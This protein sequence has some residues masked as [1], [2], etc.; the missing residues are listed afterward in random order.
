MHRNYISKQK[1]ANTIAL[2][3]LR[4]PSSN[5][6]EASCGLTASNGIEDSR[7]PISSS[8]VHHKG[9]GF[10]GTIKRPI[11]PLKLNV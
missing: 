5:M 7:L 8:P 9:G 3:N 4:C 2:V 11:A 1:I 10:S 6:V